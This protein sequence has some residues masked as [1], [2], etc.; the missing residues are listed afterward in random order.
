MPGNIEAKLDRDKFDII[1][2]AH[3][4]SVYRFALYMVQDDEKAQN[5]VL[6]AYFKAYKSL[7]RFDDRTSCRIWLLT[8]LND[9]IA[10]TN[11]I[12]PEARGQDNQESDSNAVREI[13]GIR[14][15]E[16]SAAVS[17]LSAPDRAVILLS[18][19]EGL[20]YEEIANI[21]G[22]SV[23]DVSFRLCRGR[24]LLIKRLKAMLNSRG[25]F[26]DRS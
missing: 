18:D 22:C 12:L 20:S 2:L 1:A 10:E 13:P 15:G 19:M 23:E 16:I 7:D 17:E 25:W 26:P 6:Y 21:V 3:L 9:A 5:L 8:I 11:P 4:D 24:K 14:F